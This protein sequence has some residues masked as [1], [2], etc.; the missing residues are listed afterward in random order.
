[1][2]ALFKHISQIVAWADY[3]KLL[4]RALAGGSDPE[5]APQ[6][7]A[8]HYFESFPFDQKPGAAL[9][10]VG[11]VGKALLDEVRRMAG[12]TDRA[13]GTL[14]ATPGKALVLQLETGRLKARLLASTLKLAGLPLDVQLQ[15]EAGAPSPLPSPSPSPSPAPG[16][17]DWA[18][19]L[20]V[21]EPHYHK[22]L[23]DA[24]LR[25]D[26][27]QVQALQ[28]LFAQMEGF[29]EAGDFAAARQTLK[30]LLKTVQGAQEH[31]QDHAQDG[32]E[33][34]PELSPDIWH[35]QVSQP[36]EDLGRLLSAHGEEW[37]QVTAADLRGKLDLLR[38]TV[39]WAEGEGRG[40]SDPVWV[41]LTRLMADLAGAIEPGLRDLKRD[42]WEPRGSVPALKQQVQH[43]DRMVQL[44]AETAALGSGPSRLAALER[45]LLGARD[46]Q[47]R[48]KAELRQAEGEAGRLQAQPH[49]GAYVEEQLRDARERCLD[50]RD[51]AERLQAVVDGLS[52]DRMESPDGPLPAQAQ[53][54]LNAWTPCSA[55]L[56]AQIKARDFAAAVERAEAL[57]PQMQGLFDAPYG[58]QPSMV[59][60]NCM[61]AWTHLVEGLGLARRM[62]G[63]SILQER[64]RLLVKLQELHSLERQFR[65][66]CLRA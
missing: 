43:L 64:Q 32:V 29:A 39:Q 63:T 61:N 51:A 30:R 7:Q 6:A 34:P 57:G 18:A 66:D 46:A 36:L 8:F 20:K 5:A 3:Q 65:R 16:S 56:L 17:D 14:H 33:P 44:T 2:P 53:A 15:D 52:A 37:D 48:V 59:A 4:R 35:T 31:E 49:A 12:K 9:L 25:G 1:M 54:L 19:K 55:E 28:S 10:L 21:A 42:P 22:A 58:S 41:P 27:A 38:H 24:R 45:R 26:D 23:D 60:V 11:E 13:Q 50:L 62:A 47:E 40:R